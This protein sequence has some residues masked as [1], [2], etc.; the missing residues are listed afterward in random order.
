MYVFITVVSFWMYALVQHT[1]TLSWKINILNVLIYLLCLL[2]G[3]TLLPHVCIIIFLIWKR[4]ST[5]CGC[6]IT[7]DKKAADHMCGKEENTKLK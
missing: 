7:G 2:T 5:E 4:K 1:G 6:N 3:Q